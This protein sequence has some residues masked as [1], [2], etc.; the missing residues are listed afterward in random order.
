MVAIAHIGWNINSQAVAFHQFHGSTFWSKT[1]IRQELVSFSSK[2]NT[3][4]VL[5][6]LLFVKNKKITPRGRTATTLSTRR[7]A[8]VFGNKCPFSDLKFAFLSTG[9]FPMN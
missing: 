4:R 9:F 1:E 7:S 2:G 8:A 5:L 6:L 3:K